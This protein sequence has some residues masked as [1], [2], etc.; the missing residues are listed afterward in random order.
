MLN[1]FYCS[2]PCLLDISVNVIEF[3]PVG[4]TGSEKCRRQRRVLNAIIGD[5]FKLTTTPVYGLRKAKDY[6]Y[7]A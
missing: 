6:F 3:D 4:S 7:E 2:N 5:D 1:Q